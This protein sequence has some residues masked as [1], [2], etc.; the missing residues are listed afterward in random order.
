[1]LYHLFVDPGPL[2]GLLPGTG[3][4]RYITFRTAWAVITAL[5]VTYLIFPPF[6]QWMKQQ[7]VNQ[8]I[9]SDGPESHLLNKVGTPTMGGVC[10]LLGVT[11][12]TLLWARLDVAEVW[13]ALVVLL[14]CGAIG[15]VDDWKKVMHRS[16]DGLHGRYKILAQL[17]IGGSVFGY[18]YSQ[19]RIGPAIQVPFLRD[20]AID[21][22]AASFWPDA[23]GWLGWSY[24]LFAIFVLVAESNAVN[25]TD[26]LDGLAI[27][28]VMT[29]AATYGVVA[30]V[31]GH[32]EF[33]RYLG[34]PY[35]PGVGELAVFALALVG[36]GLGF[37]WY[38]AFPASVFMGD[39]GS[40]S[41]GGTLALLAVC[42]RHE[43]LLVLVGGIFVMEAASVVLQVG[44]FKLRGKRI[45][46]M[47]PIHHH[48]EK[49]GWSEPKIIVRFWI[50][51]VLLAMVG[52]STL[53]L[54]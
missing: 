9:R 37:L 54:R 10:I 17:A 15:F 26:G 53:K 22:S 35:V 5:L 38:N 18:L 28:P 7:R 43:L 50:I 24:V 33:S 31:A 8:I 13:M 1:M 34:I 48:F 42:T 30:Y 6:I 4:F 49:K 52:L 36:A 32:Q 11:V 40:L 21:F 47:A 27:G 44:S 45:F 51:S 14:G 16:A 20:T 3:V 2:G 39:V 19:G 46:A 12:A 41:L 29:C 23:P 25:L